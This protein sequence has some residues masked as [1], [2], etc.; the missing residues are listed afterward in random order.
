MLNSKN[1]CKVY[2]QVKYSGSEDR[3]LISRGAKRGHRT[4]ALRKTYQLNI[5]T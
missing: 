1:V 4:H 2:K 5:N 3:R